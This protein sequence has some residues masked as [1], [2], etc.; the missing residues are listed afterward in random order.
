MDVDDRT[1][2][3]GLDEVAALVLES[4][5]ECAS[6]DGLLCEGRLGGLVGDARRMLELW[7]NDP[8]KFNELAARG[9][10]AAYE[11]L[12]A[13]VKAALARRGV[14]ATR[15]DPITGRPNVERTA[16]HDQRVRTQ[17]ML[18]TV[19][20]AVQS[21]DPTLA[22]F[23]PDNADDTSKLMKPATVGGEFGLECKAVGELADRLAA[24]DGK[25]GL[26]VRK[27]GSTT[28]GFEPY[29]FAQTEWFITAHSVP[30]VASQTA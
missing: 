22:Q 11:K 4:I 13:T 6:R 29:T 16:D 12:L 28:Y 18:D 19:R 7:R 3:I 14:T 24:L 8:E 26:S 21:A 15:H 9:G 17:S 30:S 5:L 1:V 25:F 20:Q 10:N 2:H 27:T 23:I